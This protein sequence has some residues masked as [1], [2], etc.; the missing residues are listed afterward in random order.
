MICNSCGVVTC[1]SQVARHRSQNERLPSCYEAPVTRRMVSKWVRDT[2]QKMIS[3]KRRRDIGHKTNGFQ[4]VMGHR[5]Q[6][7]LFASG[8]GAT[9]QHVARAREA[10][11]N[12]SKECNR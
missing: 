8:Y 6:D 2:S 12:Q 3:G 10:T 1:G 11:G 4:V 5:S 7:E 9:G